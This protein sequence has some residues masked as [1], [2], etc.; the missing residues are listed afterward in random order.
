[1]L[2]LDRVQVDVLDAAVELG[3]GELRS[4]KSERTLDELD[5]VSGAVS[6]GFLGLFKTQESRFEPR[7]D[8]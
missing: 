6:V 2:L 4:G 5:L 1:M 8:G 7:I 3:F